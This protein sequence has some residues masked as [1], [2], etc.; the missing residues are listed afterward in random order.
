MLV[1]TFWDAREWAKTY[2]E[3]HGGR[4]EIKASSLGNSL[5]TGNT[6]QVDESRLDNALLA[7]GG[8]DHSLGKSVLEL[9]V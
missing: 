1:G 5:T 2:A 6:G 4:E 7:L 3:F 9:V 8:L